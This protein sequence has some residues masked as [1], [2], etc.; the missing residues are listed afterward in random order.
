M[1]TYLRFVHF[2]KVFYFTMKRV[3]K[4]NILKHF[5][6]IILGAVQRSGPD[7]KQKGHQLILSYIQERAEMAELSSGSLACFQSQDGSPASSN[8]DTLANIFQKLQKYPDSSTAPW[9]SAQRKYLSIF[10][11]LLACLG[12]LE[13]LSCCYWFPTSLSFQKVSPP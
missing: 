5:R 11:S 6:M 3:S 10:C 12:G 7:W 9:E 1:S 4:K 8:R 2:L 13:S